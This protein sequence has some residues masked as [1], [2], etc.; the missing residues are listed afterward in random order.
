MSRRGPLAQVIG[1]LSGYGWTARLLGGYARD[2]GALSLAEAVDRITGRPAA[3]LGLADRGVLR[4]G[5]MADLVV[6]DA[7]ASA[8]WGQRC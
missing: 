6:F 2:R 7:A 4:A 8:R 3:R 5:A 1:S